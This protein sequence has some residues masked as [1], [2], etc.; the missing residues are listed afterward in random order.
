MGHIINT[1]EKT[2]L[3][4]LPYAKLYRVCSQIIKWTGAKELLFTAFSDGWDEYI[5]VENKARSERDIIVSFNILYDDADGRV[6][7]F[8]DGDEEW[9]WQVGHNA[10]DLMEVLGWFDGDTKNIKFT[11]NKSEARILTSQKQGDIILQHEEVYQSFAYMTSLEYL[12]FDSER[13]RGD[14]FHLVDSNL[15]TVE[16]VLKKGWYLLNENYID[17]IVDHVSLLEGAHDIQVVDCSDEDF[18]HPKREGKYACFIIGELTLVIRGYKMSYAI[19]K[20]ESY[21]EL[22]EN[23]IEE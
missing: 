7:V 9:F 22:E 21:E 10:T 16:Y 5:K 19:K 8:G 12:D 11:V 6:C 2:L 15:N 4:E 18:E 1:K 3:F 13:N 23:P 14:I 20:T 17:D